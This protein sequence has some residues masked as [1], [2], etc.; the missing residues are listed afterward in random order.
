MVRAVARETATKLES[1]SRRLREKGDKRNT[2]LLREGVPFPNT[3]L[4]LNLGEGE[5]ERRL[6]SFGLRRA[7]LGANPSLH[8]SKTRLAVHQLPLFVND[9]LLKRLALHAQRAFTAEVKEGMRTD[10]DEEEKEDNTMSSV[11]KPEKEARGRPPPSIVVQSKVV[12]QNDRVDLS[13]I[14]I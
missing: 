2:W 12:R 5:R 11:I 14:H 9:K 8:V 6:K 1:A 13:L 10:L 3:P 7:Q 4:A